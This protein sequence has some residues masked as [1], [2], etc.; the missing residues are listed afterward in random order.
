MKSNSNVKKMPERVETPKKDLE[1]PVDMGWVIDFLGI[2]KKTLYRWVQKNQI[3]YI[4]IG[5][6]LRFYPSKIQEFLDKKQTKVS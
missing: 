5:G 6:L 2:S 4:K 3:P 1:K